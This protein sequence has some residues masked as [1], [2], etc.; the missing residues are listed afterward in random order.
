MSRE[1]DSCVRQVKA[2]GGS[3]NAWAV[4]RASLGSDEQIKARRGKKKSK[5]L[6]EKSGGK[7]S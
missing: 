7:K 2:K 6:A 5:T 4:C 1:L 3:R